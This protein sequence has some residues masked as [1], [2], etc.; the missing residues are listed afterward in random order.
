MNDSLSSKITDSELEVMKVLWE[1]EG[2]LPITDIR[3]ALQERMGW[4]ST[5]IKTLVQRLCNKGA[6]LQSRQKVF[7]YSPAVSAEEYNDWATGNLIR[8]LYRGSA[9][10]LVA[11]LVHSDSLTRE[12]V[13]ELK[14]FFHVEGAE[15]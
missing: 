9:K 14:G 10:N 13:E 11:A 8:K 5:T 15:E 1:A 2:P 3:Q 6:V 7:L 4:E 12:D